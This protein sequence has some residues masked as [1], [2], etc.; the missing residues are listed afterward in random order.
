MFSRNKFIPL[1]L[2]YIMGAVFVIVCILSAE[3]LGVADWIKWVIFVVSLYII[4]KVIG[5]VSEKR[6]IK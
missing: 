2:T 6:N 1:W 4:F 5:V 3:W